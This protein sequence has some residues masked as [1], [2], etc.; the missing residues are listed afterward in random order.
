MEHKGKV[1][2]IG[3]TNVQQKTR[4]FVCHL[5]PKSYYAK[6]KLEKHLRIHSGEKPFKCP[7]CQ[8]CFTDKSYI[9][10]HLKTMHQIEISG[11]KYLNL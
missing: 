1:H 7:S 2:K 6:N 8:K 4:K 3:E 11:T 9:K 10:Q 5:C